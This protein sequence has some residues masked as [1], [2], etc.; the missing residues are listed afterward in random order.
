MMVSSDE[1]EGHVWVDPACGDKPVKN[2][3]DGV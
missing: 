1:Q 3:E 2:I